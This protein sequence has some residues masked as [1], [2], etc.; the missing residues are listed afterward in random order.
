M[1]ITHASER[2]CER[3]TELLMR[4]SNEN[5]FEAKQ[6]KDYNDQKYFIVKMMSLMGNCL[7]R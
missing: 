5:G 1:L 4:G 2:K 3:E 6:K 7:K